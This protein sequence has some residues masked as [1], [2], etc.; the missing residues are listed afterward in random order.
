MLNLK[1]YLLYSFKFILLFFFVI[2][3]NTDAQEVQLKEGDK[4]TIELF[5][6]RKLNGK[7]ARMDRVSITYIPSG[8]S[9]F[10]KPKE[11]KIMLE[12]VKYIF[13]E[14]GWNI[15]VTPERLRNYDYPTHEAFIGFSTFYYIRHTSMGNETKFLK[16]ICLS[17]GGNINKWLS[18]ELRLNAYQKER[19]YTQLFVNINGYHNKHRFYAGFGVGASGFWF[20]P[21]TPIYSI[22]GGVKLYLYEDLALRIGAYDYIVPPNR[23]N[24]NNFVTEIGITFAK[25]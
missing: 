10:Y 11:T 9:L 4:I 8:S 24:I 14:K 19:G 3:E 15:Y 23:K 21:I 2:I 7:F 25:W 17:G 22:G 6:S 12:K 13:N 16:G 20:I 5:N 1:K 18:L